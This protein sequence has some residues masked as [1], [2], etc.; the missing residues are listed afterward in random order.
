MSPLLKLCNTSIAIRRAAKDLSVY[1]YGLA[2]GG[3]IPDRG[4]EIFFLLGSVQFSCDYE[5][6]FYSV[7]N[8]ALFPK[9]KWLRYQ[10]VHSPSSTAEV[11]NYGA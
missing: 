11:K 6:A 1:R 9:L 4:K 8:R 5:S 7:V 10:A 2:G 3:S